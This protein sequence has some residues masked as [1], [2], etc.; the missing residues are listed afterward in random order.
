MWESGNID[1][2]DF[3]H[4]ARPECVSKQRSILDESSRNEVG[5]RLAGCFRVA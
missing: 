3:A 2:R 1:V 4:K 5:L